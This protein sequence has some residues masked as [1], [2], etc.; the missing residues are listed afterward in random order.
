MFSATS[1]LISS[2]SSSLAASSSS[3][4]PRR[5]DP[6]ILAVG[7]SCARGSAA[8]GTSW[9]P[10]VC[11]STARL[12]GATAHRQAPTSKLCKSC[13]RGF[14]VIQPGHVRLDAMSGCRQSPRIRV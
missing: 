9:R 5:W 7:S 11:C 14:P 2:S 12:T 6:A 10:R 8:L 4:S 3:S 13:Q 1:L